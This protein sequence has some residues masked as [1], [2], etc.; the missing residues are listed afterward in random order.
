MKFNSKDLMKAMGLKVGDKFVVND[1]DAFEGIWEVVHETIRRD[2]IL[3]KNGKCVYQLYHF[4]EEDISV[5]QDNRTSKRTKEE[6]QEAL[7]KI[8]S[9]M[10]VF[11]FECAESNIEDTYE[12]DAHLR[13]LQELIDNLKENE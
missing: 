6:Y 5:L 4:V 8:V 12:I 11:M 13:L 1:N 7:D 10:T 3:C 2:E 9:C